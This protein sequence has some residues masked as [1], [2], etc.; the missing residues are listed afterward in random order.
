MPCLKLTLLWLDERVIACH[1]AGTCCTVCAAAI[2]RQTIFPQF[3]VQEAADHIA[4]DGAFV[5]LCLELVSA[6]VAHAHV[7]AR[8]RHGVAHRRHADH[9]LV[10]AIILHN[11]INNASICCTACRPCAPARRLQP[12]DLLRMSSRSWGRRINRVQSK[13]G[14]TYFRWLQVPGSRPRD[15]G[16]TNAPRMAATHVWYASAEC[17]QREKSIPWH[18]TRAIVNVENVL[19]VQH[20]AQHAASVAATCTATQQQHSRHAMHACASATGAHLQLKR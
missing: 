7:A 9:A 18:P 2:G 4:A 14:A 17:L 6:A 19:E 10:A 20:A 8:E 13:P 15:R 12:I 11:T 3:D 1:G 16:D 5:G